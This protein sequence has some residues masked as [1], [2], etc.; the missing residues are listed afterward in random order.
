MKLSVPILS[1]LLV[2]CRLSLAGQDERFVEI[3]FV[4]DQT[5]IYDFG[6]VHIIQPGRFT[7]VRTLI[8]SAERMAFELKALDTLRTYC[9]RP[10]GNYPPPTDVFTLGPPDLPVKSIEVKTKNHGSLPGRRDQSKTASWYYPYKRLAAE[11]RD[12]TFSQWELYLA[13]KDV[14]RWVLP[15]PPG[16][17]W[18]KR[19]CHE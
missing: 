16:A 1:I 8:A 14:I 13:C 7:I 5:F 9:K 15:S 19:N 3:P 4:E 18:F 11:E 12:G 6:T 10:E 2:T 17:Q